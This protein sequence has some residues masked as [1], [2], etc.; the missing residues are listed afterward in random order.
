MKRA[1]KCILNDKN[2]ISIDKDCGAKS[3][4]ADGIVQHHYIKVF[5]A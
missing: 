5:E 4:V 2:P 1:I 3:N